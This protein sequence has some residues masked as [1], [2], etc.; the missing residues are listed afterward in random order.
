M[1]LKYAQSNCIHVNAP[2]LLMPTK[3]QAQLKNKLPQNIGPLEYKPIITIQAV[4]QSNDSVTRLR[5]QVPK[6]VC[7]GLHKLAFCACGVSAD[8]EKCQYNALFEKNNK[9]KKADRS[10][11]L[12]VLK[13]PRIRC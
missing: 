9:N 6:N 4:F 7:F 11:V 2:D 10:C 13:T 5:S 12:Q 1:P 3:T 8:Q